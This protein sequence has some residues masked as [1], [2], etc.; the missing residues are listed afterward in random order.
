MDV[1]GTFR[2][3]QQLVS[4]FP[5]LLLLYTPSPQYTPLLYHD[6]SYNIS[7]PARVLTSGTRAIIAQTS[8]KNLAKPMCGHPLWDK[9]LMLDAVRPLPLPPH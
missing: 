9:L 5:L 1:I 4:A 8:F 7:Y 2:T 6:Q 3:M